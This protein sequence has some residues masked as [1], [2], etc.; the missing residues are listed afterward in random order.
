MPTFSAKRC[1]DAKTC[2][3]SASGS[4]IRNGRTFTAT[5]PKC[6]ENY[7]RKSTK[8]GTAPQAAAED[9]RGTKDAPLVVEM[10][11]PPSGSEIAAEIKKNRE[12]QT[13][14]NGRAFIFNSLLVAIGILQFVALGFTVFVTNK[15]ANAANDAAEAAH[16]LAKHTRDTGRAYVKISHPPETVAI[17]STHI[18]LEST[19]PF[20]VSFGVENCG[21]TPARVSNVCIYWEIALSESDVKL[22][23]QAQTPEF[24]AFMVTKD[25][26]RKTIPITFSEADFLRIK[27]GKEILVVYGYVEYAD[28]FERRHIAGYGRTFDLGANDLVFPRTGALNDDRDI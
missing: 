20:H 12:D 5:I 21:Q 27:G 9:K 11:N 7:W 16:I 4:I 3:L 13:A 10:T 28:M 17:F 14:E 6:S 2:R 23:P 15:A 8:P 25:W 26:V 18:A 19:R 22:Y 24:R 1:A